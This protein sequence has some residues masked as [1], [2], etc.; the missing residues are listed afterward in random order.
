ML[1]TV[2]G[3]QAGSLVVSVKPT[4]GA[5]GKHERSALAAAATA[6]YVPTG[7]MLSS[8]QTRSADGVGACCS[9]CRLLHCVTGV[10]ATLPACKL[11]VKLDTHDRQS[12]SEVVVLLAEISWPATQT[13]V[14]TQARSEVA[15]GDRPSNCCRLQLV[16]GAQAR[17][18][19]V[20]AATVWYC[21]EVQAVMLLQLRSDVAVG[22][23]NCHC[24]ARQLVVLVHVM[25]EVG[26]DAT[27]CHC[28]TV[29][30][31]MDLQ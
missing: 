27:D 16:T 8:A 20:V 7:Q 13:V 24:P 22:A 30:C 28:A 12:R 3:R 2:S 5:Q 9:H 25:S 23:T 26:V 21:C 15:V 31:E 6:T 1:H 17:F 4:P 18:D 29:H 11:N 19:V 10:Q 14:L